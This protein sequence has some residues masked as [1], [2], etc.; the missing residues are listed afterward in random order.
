MQVRRQS[1]LK[2]AW[3]LGGDVQMR[4]AVFIRGDARGVLLLVGAGFGLAESPALAARAGAVF[5]HTHVGVIN[6]VLT[7]FDGPGDHI[8]DVGLPA[9]LGGAGLVRIALL[10]RGLQC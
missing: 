9:V 6:L 1:P 3:L 2:A 5:I 4:L 7:F 10:D 8:D